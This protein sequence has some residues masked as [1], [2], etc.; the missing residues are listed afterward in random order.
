MMLG[1]TATKIL[2]FFSQ[3]LFS[4]GFLKN[5]SSPHQGHYRRLVLKS[6]QGFPAEPDLIARIPRP[7]E[8]Q[9]HGSSQFT[10][11]YEKVKINSLYPNVSSDS[12]SDAAVTQIIRAPLDYLLS[13]PGKD[14]RGKLI[15]AFNEWLQLPDEKLS[16]VKEIIDLL[17][18]ASLL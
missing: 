6:P 9:G 8:V 16:I 3:I 4:F 5:F 10:E 14:I 2:K 12:Q 15:L 11:P 18:T 17:H 1:S 13:I 7:S